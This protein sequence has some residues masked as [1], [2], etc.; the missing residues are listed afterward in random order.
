[1]QQKTNRCTETIR[2][3]KRRRLYRMVGVALAVHCAAASGADAALSDLTE[4]SL[5]QL[6]NVEIVSASRYA[7]RTSDAPASVTVITAADIRAFGYRNLADALQSVR[8]FYATYDRTYNYA[9]VRGFAPPG[10]FNS[11]LLVMV[12]GIRVN[13]AI[14]DTGAIGNEF[15]VDVDLIERVEV[16]RGPSSSVYGA[17]ALFGV[18]NVI[19]RRGANIKGVE[20]AAELSSYASKRGRATLGRK[21]DNGLDMVLSVSGLRSDGPSLFYPEFSA[22]NGGIAQGTDYERY[23]KLFAKLAYGPFTLTAAQSRRDKGLLSGTL[24]TTFND[25]FNVWRDNLD[26]LDLTYFRAS[27]HWQTQARVFRGAYEFDSNNHYTVSPNVLTKDTAQGKW[28]GT[29][30]KLVNSGFERHKIVAGVEFQ[31]NHRQV[32][33]SYDADPYALYLDDRGRSQ[34]VGLYVQDEYSIAKGW[35]INAGLR[36]DKVSDQERNMSPRIGLIRNFTE[37]TTLKLLYGTA[38]R[39]PNVYESRYSLAGFNISNPAL[40]PEKI[41]TSEVILEHQLQPRTRVTATAYYYEMSGLIS[42]NVDAPT[43]LLQFQNVAGTKAAGVEFGFDHLAAGGWR[44]RGSVSHQRAEDGS[45]AALQ[46]SP[47]NMLKFNLIVPW[48]GDRLTTGLDTRFIDRRKT[49]LGGTAGAG[50][51]NLTLNY[52][53]AKSGPTL[54]ASLYNLFDRRYADPVAFDPT[55]PTRDVVQQNGRTFRLKLEH[56]F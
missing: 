28:W 49:S 48:L 35:V 19:T 22:I 13:D 20:A 2:A 1:M 6:M 47:P 18:I 21:F 36:L 53:H 51:A 39:P 23:S 55:V 14:F 34:R 33:T 43:G 8:G 12:D 44:A 11:R 38:F 40:K 42:Q 15:P 46:N 45:G 30:L 41:K 26:L 27:G 56:H 7:Q 4:L 10:D 32:Q 24:G 9:G 52:Q 25:P 17:N 16:V 5:E 37:S 3:A 54:S 50:I 29:E 31:H